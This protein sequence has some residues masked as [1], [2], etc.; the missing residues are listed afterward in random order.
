MDEA[1]NKRFSLKAVHTGIQ[2]RQGEG[3]ESFSNYFKYICFTDGKT[4]RN[5]GGLEVSVPFKRHFT[6]K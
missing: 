1:V 5:S 6:L 4:K 2:Q 3:G